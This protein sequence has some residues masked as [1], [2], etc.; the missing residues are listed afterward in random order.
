MNVSGALQAANS[1]N[2]LK[3]AV[4]IAM[5]DK[6]MSAEAAQMEK[7]LSGFEKNQ[8]EIQQAAHPYLG[9]QLDIQV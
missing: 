6:A 1:G 8:K 3:Q 4:G 9:K 2:M 5:L 7:L